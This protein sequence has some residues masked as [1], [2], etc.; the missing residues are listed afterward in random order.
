MKI[1]LI[2][3]FIND[4]VKAKDLEVLDSGG[5]AYREL[6]VGGRHDCYLP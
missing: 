6:A 5:T 4:E 2:K 3:P 1:P